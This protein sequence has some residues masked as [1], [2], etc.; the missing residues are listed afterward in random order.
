MA[1]LADHIDKNSSPG[2]INVIV[3]FSE[4]HR[5]GREISGCQYQHSLTSVQI[6]NEFKM[7]LNF[8]V[9]HR[10]LLY[11]HALNHENS[12]CILMECEQQR[13]HLL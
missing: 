4:K 1:K 10:R 5:V 7:S 13:L 2:L 9:P 11:F 8:S 6:Q 3:H 12:E